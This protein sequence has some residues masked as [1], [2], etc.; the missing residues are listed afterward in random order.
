MLSELANGAG[1][2]LWENLQNYSGN[3]PAAKRARILLKLWR[4]RAQTPPL[5]AHDFLSRVFAQ[6]NATARYQAAVPKALQKRVRENLAKLLD[7]SLQT[8]GGARPLL[9]QFLEE[10]KNGADTPAASGGV[11]LM[12]I[13]AAKGL[14]APVVV[15]ADCDFS[16][17]G[18]RGNSVDILADWSPK[19][20]TP[21]QFAASLRRRRRAYLALK[22]NAR[23]QKEREQANLLYVAATRAE[24]ALVIFSPAQ[25]KDAAEWPR[26]AMQKLAP[27]QN[28][29][30]PMAFGEDLRAAAETEKPPATAAAKNEPLGRREPHAAAAVRGEIRHKILALLLSGV[31]AKQ[32]RRLVAAEPAQW[33]EAEKIAAAPP[34]Q[35][36]LKNAREILAEREFAMEQKIIRP[37]LVV[38]GE[39]AGKKTAWI[40]DYKTAARPEHH[41]P[42]LE[43]YRHAVSARYPEYKT[44]LAIL[45]IR[46]KMHF[47]D[48][49]A[50]ESAK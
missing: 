16:H 20:D 40:V 23:E 49:A 21:A 31:P 29:E 47:L 3:E 39:E 6:G 24:Q 44:R 4:R 17:S 14:Q 32:A 36:I 30:S 15:I 45:D 38:I 46:G 8:D 9:A 50:A 42:Q 28:P 35:K 12:S 7:F 10:A 11:R 5:P 13:H 18:G 41:R 1:D 43:S 37:D 48:D 25:P 26:A 33:R 19:K 34:L 22:Q 27:E 2:S